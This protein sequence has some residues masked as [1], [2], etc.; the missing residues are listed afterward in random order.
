MLQKILEKNSYSKRKNCT[1]QLEYSEQLIS[2][3]AVGEAT[4]SLMAVNCFSK[5]GEGYL[6]F[7]LPLD[8]AKHS[9]VKALPLDFDK[10]ALG[11]D[12]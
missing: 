10:T 12:M 9:K 8:E 4:C 3:S 6:G 7:V 1:G 11:E 2:K 5:R